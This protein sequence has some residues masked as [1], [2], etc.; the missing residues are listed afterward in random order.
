[1][2]INLSIIHKIIIKN[3]DK[4]NIV[5][6]NS[7]DARKSYPPHR[8]NVVGELFIVNKL[9]GGYISIMKE[10]LPVAYAVEIEEYIYF[11]INEIKGLFRIN[12]SNI[13]F[14]CE[15]PI[16]KYGIS[17]DYLT[18]I[19]YDSFIFIIP[20][21]GEFL[22]KYNIKENKI[23]K[24]KISGMDIYNNKYM[25]A[26]INDDDLYLFSVHNLQIVKFNISTEKF[27]KL[28]GWEKI[29]DK[30]IFD[31]EDAIFRQQVVCVHENIFIPF[32]TA[33]AIL[34][35]NIKDLH[36]EII[37][38]GEDNNGYS[39]ISCNNNVLWCS[40]RK[41]NGFVVSY[42]ILTGEIK[43]YKLPINEK[44]TY[45]GIVAEEENVRLFS[46]T[47]I[48]N[49]VVQGTPIR[50]VGGEYGFVNQYEKKIIYYNR[51]ESIIYKES[52]KKIE[53]SIKLKLRQEDKFLSKR[54]K[55]NIVYES[56]VLGDI[57]DFIACII[58]EKN[59]VE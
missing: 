41:L 18:M 36:T 30:L 3:A 45:I 1:M 24:I 39:G 57:E 17:E 6:Y 46:S 38:L 15:I 49:I 11:I 31:K 34:K 54:V 25:P 53:Q 16:E 58:N 37:R 20:Y 8:R 12:G 26:L 48:R 43:K 4:N 22:L 9:R 21:N 52:K 40:P 35:I 55:E 44:G 2:I 19:P 56:S 33:N 51:N 14:L 47:N 42:N 13:E 59:D 27:I 10:Y 28:S 29:A 7:M 50:I 5:Y 32:C 23:Y